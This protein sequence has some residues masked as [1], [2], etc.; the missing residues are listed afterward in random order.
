L[1]SDYKF[2][3]NNKLETIKI[4]GVQTKPTSIKLDGEM[5]FTDFEYNEM[6][7]VSLKIFPF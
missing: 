6:T 4:F 3:E 7:H 1:K 2:T 5:A